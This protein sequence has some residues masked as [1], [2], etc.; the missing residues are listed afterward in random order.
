[1]HAANNQTFHSDG[2]GPLEG[3]SPGKCARDHDLAGMFRSQL[4]GLQRL[5][6]GCRH[7]HKRSPSLSSDPED[8]LDKGAGSFDPDALAGDDFHHT[9][10]HIT[11][12][13]QTARRFT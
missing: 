13:I 8:P 2:L 1:M 6:R 10:I 7:H 4:A 9:A 11:E 12:Q 5:L 3:F